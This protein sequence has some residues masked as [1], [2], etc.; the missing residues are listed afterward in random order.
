MIDPLVE[1]RE[2]PGTDFILYHYTINEMSSSEME[3][4]TVM[5]LLWPWYRRDSI[6][7]QP[8]SLTG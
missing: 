2:H 4:T 8:S 5:S 3:V 7:D 6:E 1:I